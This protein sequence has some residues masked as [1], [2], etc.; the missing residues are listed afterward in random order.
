[1][2][3]HVGDDPTPHAGSGAPRRSATQLA[4]D[5]AFTGTYAAIVAGI[6]TPEQFGAVGDGTTNDTAALQAA[7]D[8]AIAAKGRVALAAKTYAFTA[9]TINGS[10]E[11]V[12]TG[13]LGVYGTFA[14]GT[15]N[16]TPTVAPFLTGC[17]LKCTAS[18]N[19]TAID[20]TGESRQ[21]NLRDFG[22]T[23][24]APFVN[25]GHGIRANPGANKNGLAG[26]RWDNIQVWGHDGNSYAFNLTNFAQGTFTH[27][28]AWGGGLFRLEQN[29]GSQY[30]NSTFLGC[31]V[32]LLAG[33]GAHGTHLVSTS[34]DWTRLAFVGCEWNAVNGQSVTALQ[35]YSFT[36]PTVSQLIFKGDSAATLRG[37]SFISPAFDVSTSSVSPP[38]FPHAYSQGGVFLD[39]GGWYQA[40]AGAQTQ[41]LM[42]ESPLVGS[43]PFDHGVLPMNVDNAFT[44]TSAATLTATSVGTIRLADATS[45][46]F[47]VTLPT[48]A[49]TRGRR[50]TIKKIDA[51][52]NAV[53]VG[54]AGGNIDGATTYA[55]SAQWAFVEVYSDGAKWNIVAKS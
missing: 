48:A 44:S 26:A 38:A 39:P 50:Y 27:L 16:F 13:A 45:A 43:S 8:A 46:A 19:A 30:G 6:V 32:K 25:T 18:G 15:G 7:I 54:T 14:S 24:A 52:A 36:N 10:C 47:T 11:I 17:V 51:S 53:T 23:W 55:L 35:G 21:V 9:L 4:S 28:R 40:A 31:M 37:L 33:G 2:S 41:Y 29:Q 3:D 34:G 5:P 12:G 1:M 20:I 42:A 22:L 49:S